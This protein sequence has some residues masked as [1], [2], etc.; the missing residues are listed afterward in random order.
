MLVGVGNMVDVAVRVAEKLNREGLDVGVANARFVKPFDSELFI[1]LAKQGT[2]L[3]FLEE[4]IQAGGFAS[5]VVM[6]LLSAGCLHADSCL[7]VAIEDEFVTHGSKDL[8]HQDLGFDVP[9][10][11]SK[12]RNFIN[13]N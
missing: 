5:N 9:S 13:K 2:K 12:V 11:V 3:I 10:L 8:L 1:G 4:N 7:S 6:N